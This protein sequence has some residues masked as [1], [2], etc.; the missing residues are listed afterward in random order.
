MKEYSS[1]ELSK[2]SPHQFCRVEIHRDQEFHALWYLTQLQFRI[3][4]KQKKIEKVTLKPKWSRSSRSYAFCKSFR[5]S[6]ESIISYS[7]RPILNTMAQDPMDLMGG[8]FY[9]TAH[10]LAHHWVYQIWGE[11]QTGHGKMWQDA[12]KELFGIANA[13]RLHDQRCN[14]LIPK[15][16]PEIFWLMWDLYQ[17]WRLIP[18]ADWTDP[19]VKKILSL[20]D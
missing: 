17:T 11:T 3:L 13:P 6:R 2:M 1:L 12:M 5:L 9:T 4:V 19:R 14:Q 8:V 16:K 15:V 18:G 20:V 7:P 10:E